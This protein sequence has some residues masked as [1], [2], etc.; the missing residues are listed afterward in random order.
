M[1]GYPL[2][3]VFSY[4]RPYTFRFRLSLVSSIL[5]KIFDLMPP[6][7]VG[8]V[9]DSVRGEAPSWI[10]RLAGTHDPL[11]IAVILS[12]TAVVIFAMESFFQW[13]YQYGFMTTAQDAQHDIRMKV[14]DHIQGR[15]LAFFE[16]HRV[17]DTLSILNDDVNQ[18]ERFL[19]TGFNECLQLVVLLG[20]SS[21]I[22][23][24]ISWPLSIVGILPVP[25]ILWGGFF[26]RN[27]VAPHY[28]KLRE[29]VGALGSRLENNLA[30]I[31][32]I[33]SFTAEQFEY[34]R[35]E[36]AS[37]GYKKANLNA[38][39]WAAVYVPIIR[40]AVVMG[41]AG[42]LLVGSYWVLNNSGIITVGELVLFAM[43]TERLL[44]PLTG[45]GR[46]VDDL[47]RANASAKRILTL[48]ATPSTI[49]D[50]PNPMVLNQV[51]GELGFNNLSFGYNS[52]QL[53]L[54]SLSFSIKPGEI[55]GIAGP[56]GSGKSTLIK[57]LM[58]FYDPL[59]GE[60]TLEGHSLQNLSMDTI[61]RSIALVSQDVYLFHGTIYENIAYSCE[62]ST[63]HA[64]MEAS[65][66]AEL[67]SFVMSLPDGYNT[68]VGERGIK[69]SGGQ[70]QR[71][72]IARA[73]LKDAPIMIFD[74]ATSS[75]DTETEKA[76][77]QN[78]SALIQGKTALI[79]AHRLSTI[80]HAHRILV[81]D[82][83][84]LK[85][86]GSHEELLQKKGV[87]SDLWNVQIGDVG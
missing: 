3:G 32:V 40:M 4:L 44:W 27:L 17:G 11:H 62:N 8:W 80:R 22:L 23:I 87:Y 14:Y 65:K 28:K 24:G 54:K 69:L 16:N 50:P 21:A 53:I 75:V 48:L 73:I 10:S 61:R 63:E 12:V 41:F 20:V 56:T 67:H 30:G 68:V 83:G 18:L 86:E 2:F 35:V 79:I 37:L 39:K 82:N 42:V 19:N 49:Q 31:L 6:L 13:G 59:S 78:L 60:A 46:T 1:F 74:E 47:E 81:I 33:K 7:L 34:K 52:S 66:K 26:Y 84:E 43:M 71:L 72:S 38:I 51:K 45:L 76:I 15:E 55:V 58:R 77:Q 57:L 29:A 25:L 70:R 85:E 9:I 5:N 64:V 36:E